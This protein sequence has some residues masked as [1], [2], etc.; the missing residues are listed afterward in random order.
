MATADQSTV[1]ECDDRLGQGTPQY[2]S[3][4]GLV[5]DRFDGPGCEESDVASLVTSRRQRFG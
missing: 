1:D 4:E 3:V 2:P 5:S